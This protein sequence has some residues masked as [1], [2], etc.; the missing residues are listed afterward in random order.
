MNRRVLFLLIIVLSTSLR[1]QSIPRRLPE[2]IVND[3]NTRYAAWAFS[4]PF[5]A[6]QKQFRHE[7]NLYSPYCLWGDFDGNDSL[8]YALQIFTTVHQSTQL[9]WVVYLHQHRSYQ[10]YVLETKGSDT[11]ESGFYFLLCPAGSVGSGKRPDFRFPHDAIGVIYYATA[12][13]AYYWSDGKFHQLQI[14][15]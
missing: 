9:E 7:P 15:D 1:G 8:D 14:A 11:P 13:R 5:P 12:G 6:I 4:Q 2:S 3:L 10:R